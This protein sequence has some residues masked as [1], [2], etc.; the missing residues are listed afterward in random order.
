LNK[1]G[2]KLQPPLPREIGE[3]KFGVADLTAGEAARRIS[4]LEKMSTYELRR[5]QAHIRYRQGRVKLNEGYIEEYVVRSPGDSVVLYPPIPLAGGIVRKAEAGDYLAR[6]Q[7][8][9]RLP[10]FSTRVVR[11]QVPEHAV[12]KVAADAVLNFQSRAFPGR[13]FKARV[14][15]ISN[16]ASERANCPGQKFFDVVAQIQ[17][18]GGVDDLKPGMVVE[19][20]FLVRNHGLVFA[21]PKDLSVPTGAGEVSLQLETGHGWAKT[22]IL[23]KP[24]YVETDDHL[25]VPP[26]FFSVK[27]AA[28]GQ[29]R[30]LFPNEDKL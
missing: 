10:D 29:L 5:R 7:V 24:G 22:V 23:N 12:Q 8:F 9:I 3:L 17:P 30:I 2:T 20:E 11:L 18:G 13:S 27:G 25:L 26:D 6:D 1:E 28:A 15:S 21:I 14:T 4:Q 19:A 16:L